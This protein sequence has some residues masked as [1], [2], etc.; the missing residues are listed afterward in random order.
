MLKT[1]DLSRRPGLS[2]GLVSQL[3]A[4]RPQCEEAPERQSPLF[5][6]RISQA[7]SHQRVTFLMAGARPPMRDGSEHRKH[8][9]MMRTDVRS[10]REGS[11][12]SACAAA[13]ALARWQKTWKPARRHDTMS[14]EGAMMGIRE[15]SRHRRKR[16]CVHRAG[17]YEDAERWDLA[18]WQSR[19]PQQ[20]LDALTAILEDVR[21]VKGRRP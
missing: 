13:P 3:A 10:R 16:I 17:D 20:R 1:L 8:R 15:R 12:A 11:D 5:G 2:G 6:W 9:R 4:A 19:T 21:K 18:Y 14:F 7:F